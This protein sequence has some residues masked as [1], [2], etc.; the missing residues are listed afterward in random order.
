MRRFPINFTYKGNHANAMKLVSKARSIYESMLGLSNSSVARSFTRNLLMEGVG[1]IEMYFVK[2]VYKDTL[3]CNTTITGFGKGYKTSKRRVCRIIQ[4]LDSLS[5]GLIFLPD[6][7]PD[8]N[9][10]VQILNWPIADQFGDLPEDPYY[11]VPG[12]SDFQN[13][14]YRVTGL[15]WLSENGEDCVSW[16]KDYIVYNDKLISFTPNGLSENVYVLTACYYSGKILYTTPLAPNVINIVNIEDGVITTI[17]LSSDYRINRFGRDP[18]KV[19][20][21]QGMWVGD[22][23]TSFGKLI[24]LTAELAIDSEEDIPIPGSP[25]TI[26]YPVGYRDG[27]GI[28]CYSPDNKYP[29]LNIIKTSSFTPTTTFTLRDN[30]IGSVIDVSSSETISEFPTFS[31]SYFIDNS[32]LVIYGTLEFFRSDFNTSFQSQGKTRVYTYYRGITKKVYEYS[33]E[34]LHYLDYI[35]IADAPDKPEMFSSAFDGRFFIFQFST[36]AYTI[37]SGG[38]FGGINDTYSYVNFNRWFARYQDKNLPNRNTLILDLSSDPTNENPDE[39]KYK[40]INYR[41]DCG[42]YLDAYYT[43]YIVPMLLQAQ[44]YQTTTTTT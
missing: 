22:I 4:L 14:Y 11:D 12:P 31:R 21:S 18:L 1:L 13:N 29:P 20:A 9:E 39:Y 23:F 41:Y 30:V 42:R 28:I 26:D 17:A 15:P 3:Q 40:L 6:N 19:Y 5:S 8:S 27:E 16:Y 33:V 43:P 44:P 34:G 24:T 32:L 7:D 35:F 10:F 37:R 36:I 38:G 2:D 25:N